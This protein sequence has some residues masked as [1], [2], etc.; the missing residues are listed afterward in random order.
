MRYPSLTLGHLPNTSLN[1][2]FA[3]Q[4]ACVMFPDVSCPIVVLPE[5]AEVGS[6]IPENRFR[7][8]CELQADPLLNCLPRFHAVDMVHYENMKA[9]FQQT[10]TLTLNLTL[11]L[12]LTLT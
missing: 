10:L 4:T 9:C 2:G 6:D 8:I 11:N 12:T 1:L 7:P 3:L 5:V